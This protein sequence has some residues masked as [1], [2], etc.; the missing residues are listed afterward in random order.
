[1][2]RGLRVGISFIDERSVFHEAEAK[3][4][5]EDHGGGLGGLHIFSTAKLPI[6]AKHFGHLYV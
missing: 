3:K 2:A 5:P 1:V 6:A 4:F